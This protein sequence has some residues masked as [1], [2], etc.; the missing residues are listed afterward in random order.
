MKLTQRIGNWWNEKKRLRA[1]LAIERA[2]HEA[3]RTQLRQAASE[4]EGARRDLAE[5]EDE[6]AVVRKKRNELFR[7]VNEQRE[8]IVSQAATL[9]GWKIVRN[10]N[11][12]LIAK[13]D[14][15]IADLRTHD[16]RWNNSMASLNGL[17]RDRSAECEDLR[18]QLRDAQAALAKHNRPVLFARKPGMPDTALARILSGKTDT[19]EVRALLEIV[20]ECAVQAMSEAASAPVAPITDGPNASRGFT[21]EDRTFSSGG[22]FAL[23]Q[24]KQRIEEFLAVRE[25]E[26]A[27]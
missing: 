2:E 16:E 21:A 9:D 22:V 8:M 6:L 13:Q 25:E 26:E 7:Q 18:Q 1:L 10:H 15:L 24:L 12:Q 17:L 5:C 19:D 27:A 14:L 11:E 3:A 23:T 4:T 20:D